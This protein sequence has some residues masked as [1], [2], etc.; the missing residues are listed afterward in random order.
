M[1]SDQDADLLTTIKES[2]SRDGTQALDCLSSLSAALGTQ[3]TQPENL[4]QNIMNLTITS[5]SLDQ[6]ALRV[7]A[8]H[9][10][11]RRQLS[12][13][14]KQLDEL[15]SDS[16][17]A[18]SDLPTKTI[19]WTRTSKHLARKVQEYK[20]RLS[21]LDTSKLPSPTLPEVIEE[22]RA[23]SEMRVKVLGLEG[24]AKAFRGLPHD[25]DL[26]R[27]EVESVRRELE[28]LVSK[29]DGLFEGLV[30]ESGGSPIKQR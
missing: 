12:E 16:F 20:D 17:A 18:S 24:Q 21:S 6:Q 7:S 9:S 5:F 26:A 11:L 25:K 30:E 15:Q 14:Q 3:K 8:L 27:L 13:L 28:G 1:K 10:Q 22:E 4:A 2:L 19:E 29:R 23:L